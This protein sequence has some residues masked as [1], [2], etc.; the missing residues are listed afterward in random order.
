MTAPTSWA[1]RLLRAVLSGGEHPPLPQY[2][3]ARR[4]EA[5]DEPLSA[6][7][8]RALLADLTVTTTEAALVLGLTRQRVHAL[9]KAAMNRRSHEAPF[10]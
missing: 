4:Y 10:T 7:E 9:R 3:E 2:A 6:D 8:R 1:W 5:R